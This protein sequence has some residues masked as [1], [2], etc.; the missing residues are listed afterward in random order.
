MSGK[1]QAALEAV[2]RSENAHF[3]RIWDKAARGQRLLL[4]ALARQPL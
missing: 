3:S 1:P 2:F 4:Q